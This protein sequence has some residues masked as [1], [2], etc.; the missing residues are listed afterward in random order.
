MPES[1]FQ[2]PRLGTVHIR[3][4]ASTRR[5]SA[6]WRNG[7]IYLTVPR[8]IGMDATRE[9]F[10]QLAD[11]LL[12][13]RPSKSY[14]DS[15]QLDFDGFSIVIK[16][17]GHFPQKIMAKAGRPVSVIEVGSGLDFADPETT[18]AVSK[19][20]CRIASSLA[21][22][23]LLPEA[24]ELSR[25]LGKQPKSWTISSGH[26]ILG[27]CSGAGVIALSYIVVFLP[28]HLRHYVV[29]H[30]LAHLDEMNHGPGFHKLCDR[31]CSGR[32]RQYA[33]EL[34]RFDWPVLR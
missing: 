5:L 6:K 4:S 28:R 27:R 19:M 17:Q 15:Q 22:Q 33:K 34:H 26:R 24:V 32:E 18:K 30:E 16:R 14:H 21:E 12:K 9:L 29:C 3:R 1:Q 2:H 10:E 20:M 13:S 11:R 25:R 8:G 23:I 7:E 31:Y